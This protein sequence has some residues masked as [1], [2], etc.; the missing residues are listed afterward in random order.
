MSAP[1]TYTVGGSRTDQRRR[2]FALVVAFLLALTSLAISADPASAKKGDPHQPPGNPDPPGQLVQ[3]Q[4][5]A[6]NDYHGHLE[7]NTPGTA[8]DVRPVAP[9]ICPPSSTSCGPATSTA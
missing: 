5:L 6:F 7:A 4:L 1:A 8:D 3:V 9:S 2:L